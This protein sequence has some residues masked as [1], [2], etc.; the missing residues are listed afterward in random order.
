MKGSSL[1]VPSG[2]DVA[3]SAGL[4][5]IERRIAR[6]LRGAYNEMIEVGRC[7]V[8]AK[9][10]GLVAHGL[11]EQWVRDQTGMSERQ[12]QKLMQVARSVEPDSVMAG[13]PISKIQAIL[14]LPEPERDGMAER[15]ESESLTLRQLREEIAEVKRRADKREEALSK[16]VGKTAD[17]L[18]I[19]AEALRDLQSKQEKLQLELREAKK[20]AAGGVSPEAR[21]KIERLQAELAEAEAYAEQQAEQRQEAQREML[22]LQSQAARGELSTSAGFGPDDLATAVRTFLGSAGVMPHM[23]AVLAAISTADRYVYDQYIDMIATWVDGTRRALASTILD[24][25]IDE[26]G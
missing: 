17:E 10:G 7:L 11:W 4:D 23:G 19:K 22:A 5:Y 14:S 12:A 8:E 16:V 3:T 25:E 15:V 6:H 24:G 13:L 21:A 26:E 2:A 9:D 20:K 18:R 1:S